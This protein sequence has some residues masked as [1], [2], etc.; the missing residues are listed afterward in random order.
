MEVAEEDRPGWRQVVCGLCATGSDETYVKFCAEHHNMAMVS[1]D[2]SSLQADSQPNVVGLVW[3]SAITWYCSAVLHLLAKQHYSR[4]ST[5]NFVL[6]IAII[7]ILDQFIY[8]NQPNLHVLVHNIRTCD[9]R[10]ITI[11]HNHY[12]SYPHH[13]YCYQCQQGP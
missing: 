7:R 2:D 10:H 6:R 9:S 13:N 5:I 3:R 8:F 4:N 12:G 11:F 1:A